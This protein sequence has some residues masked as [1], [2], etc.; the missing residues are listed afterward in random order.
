MLASTLTPCACQLSTPYA[1][2]PLVVP[3]C[4]VCA[5]FGD[6]IGT[7]RQNCSCAPTR[8]RSGIVW[9]SGQMP[10]TPDFHTLDTPQNER[11]LN[12]TQHKHKLNQSSNRNGASHI[13][14]S[15]TIQS[16][17]KSSRLSSQLTSRPTSRLSSVRFCHQSSGLVTARRP[18]PSTHYFI[19]VPLPGGIDE[20]ESCRGRADKNCSV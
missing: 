12:T 9:Y 8:C 11:K 13:A 18:M 6:P 1:C 16:K 3:L 4:C 20:G 5:R 17:L 19:Y 10:R 2:L 15:C 14:R 7:A